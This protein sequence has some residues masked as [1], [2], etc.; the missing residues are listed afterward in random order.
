MPS[1][2]VQGVGK[3]WRLEETQKQIDSEGVTHPCFSN[4]STK[5]IC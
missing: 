3:G 4:L 5:S 2:I 1:L